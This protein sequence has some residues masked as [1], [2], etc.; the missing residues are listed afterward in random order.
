MLGHTRLAIIDLQATANQPMSNESGSVQVVFNGEIYNFRDLTGQLQSNHV[1]RSVGDTEVL[2]HGYEE[3]G[4]EG[5]LRRLRGM[6]AFALW[7]DHNQTLHVARD[8]LGEKPLYYYAQDG[9]FAFTSTL[10][11]LLQLLDHRPAVSGRAIGNYLTFLAVPGSQSIFEGIHKLPP[12]HRAEIYN[13]TAN[14][15]QYWRISF[16]HKE[17]RTFTEWVDHVDAQIGR[18]VKEQLVADVPIG[19]FLSGGVDSSLVAS[20]ASRLSTNPIKTISAGFTDD[21]LDERPFAQTVAKHLG[22]DHTELLIKPE[23]ASLLPR[24]VNAAGEPFADPAFL[25][26][27]ALAEQVTDHATVVLTGDGGDEL[28]AGYPSPLIARCA[29]L[30][31]RA[32]PGRVRKALPRHLGNTRALK[33]ATRG[34]RRLNRLAMP[35]QG[36]TFRWVYDQLAEKGFRGRLGDILTDEIRANAEGLDV[37]V[38][39]TNTFETADGPSLADRVMATEMLTLLPDQFLVKT[40]RATMSASLEARGPLLSS[41]LAETAARIPIDT[42]LR[43]LHSKAVLRGVASKHVPSTIAKRPK[44]GFAVPTSAWMKGPLL[45][46]TSGLLLSDTSI[47]RGILQPATV[48][49]L[50]A[51][52]ESGR[53]DHGQRLWALLQLELWFLMFVDGSLKPTDVL[54]LH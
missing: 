40:D 34:V 46:T 26:T 50:V 41:E 48:R 30:Y 27:T 29:E 49:R 11:A 1:F 44:R 7:D 19:V 10:P 4:I 42:H 24:M 33:G 25:P 5:L 2:V 22:T 8:R 52:H 45:K 3:W 28:F 31:M 20:W 36:P 6:F 37:D 9:L 39:W 14:I 15:K 32:V 54:D 47:K 12:G 17:K 23:L 21:S 43:G 18:S 16:A 13:G 53:A 35:S 38:L 51:D